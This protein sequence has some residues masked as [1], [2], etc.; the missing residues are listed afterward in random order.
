MLHASHLL[1]TSADSHPLVKGFT[2]V[3]TDSTPPG[4]SIPRAAGPTGTLEV[5]IP[6]ELRD[7]FGGARVAPMSRMPSSH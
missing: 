7:H 4:I 1:S 3:A 2:R 6:L 5:P